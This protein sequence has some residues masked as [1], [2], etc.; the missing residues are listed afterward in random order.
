MLLHLPIS[1]TPQVQDDDFLLKGGQA[2][3]ERLAEPNAAPGA[4]RVK[5]RRGSTI[6]TR[7]DTTLASSPSLTDTIDSIAGV[8]P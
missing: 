2:V 1:R 7:T 3:L 5:D 4:R 8:R 6:V